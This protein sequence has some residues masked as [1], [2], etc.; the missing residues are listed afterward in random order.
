MHGLLLALLPP[1][2]MSRLGA[3]ENMHTQEAEANGNDTL[4]CDVNQNPGTKGPRAGFLWPSMLTRHQI[5]SFGKQRLAT[6]GES[7]AALGLD[8][9]SALSGGRKLTHLKAATEG[10]QSRKL[11]FMCGNSMHA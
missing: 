1:G 11:K 7:C 9:Y 8:W 6:P 2:A 5:F 3:Y 4:L 10:L